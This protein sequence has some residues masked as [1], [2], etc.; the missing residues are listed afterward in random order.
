[1][2]SYLNLD[3]VALTLFPTFLQKCLT[4]SRYSVEMAAKDCYHAALVFA[5]AGR[6]YEEE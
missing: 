1:M 2:S 5:E 4:N 6:E 3:E